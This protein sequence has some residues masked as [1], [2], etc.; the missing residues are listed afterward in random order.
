MAR[1]ALGLLPREPSGARASSLRR[2]FDLEE[3]KAQMKVLKGGQ[4]G[5][6]AK[7]A[8]A[9]AAEQL[10]IWAAVSDENRITL[11]K[12]GG[13]ATLVSLLV[14][15]SDEAKWHAARAL[16]NLANN[17][18]AKA[19]IIKE[20]AVPTLQGLVKHGKGKLKEAADETLK[21]L[22]QQGEKSKPAAE[23]VAV[24]ETRK[25]D[26][27]HSASPKVEDAACIPSGEGS[28]VAMFSARFDGGPVEQTLG[29]FKFSLV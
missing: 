7:E 1:E 24:P 14:N 18:E 12:E 2:D 25:D 28:R 6:Q 23:P 5:T 10:A 16:R 15:G 27:K 19:A 21:L 11:T 8:K 13:T 26:K 22:A 20:D 3:F 4:E 9:T 29:R 17:K